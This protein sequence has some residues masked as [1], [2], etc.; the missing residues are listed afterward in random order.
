MPLQPSF[1]NNFTKGLKTE[2]TGLNFPEDA[3]YDTDNCVYTLIGDV[4][5]RSGIDYEDNFALHAVNRTNAAISSY[6][7]NNAG[8][9]GN[10]QVVV[11]QVGHILYF[12]QSSNATTVSP[13]STTLL[14]TTVDINNFL[15]LNSTAT[16]SL[17]ECQYAVGNGYLFVFHPN[18]DPF[19]VTFSPSAIT[20]L[21]IDLRIRDF[22]GVPET[23]ADNFR[24]LTLSAEHN[25]NLVNQGWTS[26]TAW[27]CSFNAGTSNAWPINNGTGGSWT[28]NIV[29]QTNTTSVTVGSIISVTAQMFN[30]VAFNNFLTTMTG[31]VTAYST[32]FTSITITVQTNNN[33]S[34]FSS[35][36]NANA[37]LSS[38]GQINTWFTNIHNYPSNS[39][40]WWLYKNSSGVFDPLGTIANVQQPFSSAPKGYFVLNAFKQYRTTASSIG[41]ITAITTTARPSTGCWF[42][43][44]I[45]YAGVNASQPAT[46]DEPFYTWT[47]NIYFS[48]I[49]ERTSQFGNC[50]QANDPTS[51]NLFDILP[52][53]GGVIS[54][55]GSGNIYKLFSLKFGLLVLAA[56][57]IWYIGGSSGIGF[58]ATDFSVTRI[59][60]IQC[61]S[62]T[63]VVDVQG[64][65]MFWNEEG[66][67]YVAPSPQGGS[68]RSPDIALEVTNLCLGSILTFYASI[69]LQSKKF[70]RGDYNPL[71]YVVQWCYRSTNENTVTDRY[72]FDKILN[73]NTAN[74]A[75][76]PWTIG[77]SG[78]SPFIH[79][80]RYVAGPGGST[81][82]DPTFKYLSSVSSGNTYNFTFS[83]ERDDVNWMDWFSSSSADYTS[84]FTTGYHLGGKG[85]LKFNPLYLF[86][87]SN[88][89]TNTQYKV[90]GIWDYAVNRNSNKWGS[91]QLVTNNFS[92]SNFNKTFRRHKIRGHGYVLQY[93]IQSVSGQP[94]DI[95]GWTVAEQPNMAP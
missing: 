43:G 59:S 53:D 49:V 58:T 95:Q 51:Q 24:P 12:Y 88:N 19:Y 90:Q 69:P 66:I 7:W 83:E 63:S 52:D 39:D 15:A 28:G 27:T 17:T 60:A 37:S 70:A 72:Q 35:Y 3:A 31:V 87:Y 34:A 42:Q 25:Y 32:P 68:A 29:S 55:P 92:T 18:C 61:I 16:P 80:I 2:F 48:Q 82:P 45:F 62:G 71:S 74:K 8:G 13:L 26:G 67:Y 4:I 91:I 57:G 85:I 86:V 76:Y 47:E 20:A 21:K 78:T 5:R 38:L 75:F 65:P 33:N 64:F 93:K 10:T 30:G 41:G 81:S 94:F 84:F 56:N 73:F 50:F 54:I 40:V 22:L 79:D 36:T 1:I 6:K 14:A 11:I 46:G 89:L 44:R 77:N 9:D 23:I